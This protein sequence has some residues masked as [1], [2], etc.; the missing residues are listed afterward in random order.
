MGGFTMG[1]SAIVIISFT[2]TEILQRFALL[3][4]YKCILVRLQAE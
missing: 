1:V 4:N 2:V 3:D